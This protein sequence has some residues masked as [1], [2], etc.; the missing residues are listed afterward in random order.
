MFNMFKATGT[1]AVSGI[2]STTL[3]Q[4]RG[5]GGCAIL[6]NRQLACQITPVKLHSDRMVA[7]K[8]CVNSLPI[9]L[10]SVYM[11]C[12]TDSDRDNFF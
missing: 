3:L 5:Y 1:H 11:P 8:I 9:P 4:G 7:V 2:D 12:D 6:W 10:F